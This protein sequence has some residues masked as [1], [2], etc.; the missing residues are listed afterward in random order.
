[1]NKSENLLTNE[2]KVSGF[3]LLSAL[4]LRPSG[5]AQL[6][7]PKQNRRYRQ[8][9]ADIPHDIRECFGHVA[10]IEPQLL[11]LERIAKPKKLPVGRD[12]IKH[13]CPQRA[14]HSRLAQP[15]FV[16]GG[17]VRC[18]ASRRFSHEVRHPALKRS[19]ERR[20]GKECRSRWSP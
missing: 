7:L 3:G 18:P 2:T 1:M 9:C 17:N 6:S 4:G 19:E 13:R 20:V 14:A 12:G 5:L 15:D 10:P 16:L 8:R 11:V